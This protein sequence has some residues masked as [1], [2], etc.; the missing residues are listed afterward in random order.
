MIRGHNSN[1]IKKHRPKR[2]KYNLIAQPG[3]LSGKMFSTYLEVTVLNADFLSSSNSRKWS[4][5]WDAYLQI[6]KKKP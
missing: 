5:F 6:F 2:Y 4:T 1:I 3:S